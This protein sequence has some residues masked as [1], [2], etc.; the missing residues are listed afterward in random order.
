M[1]KQT[2]SD[3]SIGDGVVHARGEPIGV[4]VAHDHARGLLQV[5]WASGMKERVRPTEIRLLAPR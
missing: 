2:T 3:F 1:K 5:K 4:V